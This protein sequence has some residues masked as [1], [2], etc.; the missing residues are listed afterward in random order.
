MYQVTQLDGTIVGT[1]P[2]SEEAHTIM[3]TVCG[4]RGTIRNTKTGDTSTW[5]D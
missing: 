4:H 5:M 2:T 3:Y 1:Y